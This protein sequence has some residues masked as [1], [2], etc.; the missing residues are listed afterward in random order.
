MKLY[1]QIS[2]PPIDLPKPLF[3][4]IRVR[5]RERAAAEEAPVGREGRRMRG[6]QNEMLRWIDQDRFFPGRSAPE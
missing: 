5:G 6:R 1:I 4:E 3:P 2:Q